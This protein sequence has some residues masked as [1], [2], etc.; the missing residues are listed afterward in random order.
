M[1]DTDVAETRE[2]PFPASSKRATGLING[3]ASEITRL[4]FSDKIIITI[5]QGGRL[6]HW[7]GDGA[8]LFRRRS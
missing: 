6:A 2:E 3:T 4:D 1:A 7:V 8:Q 5:S